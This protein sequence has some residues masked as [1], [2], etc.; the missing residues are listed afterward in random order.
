MKNFLTIV[1]GLFV[2]LCGIAALSFL[3]EFNYQIRKTDPVWELV[4]SDEFTIDG[5]PDSKLWK[6]DIGDGCPRL[7]GWGNNELQYYTD[8]IDNVY[9]KNGF[10]HIKAIKD[11]MG[12]RNYTSTRIKSKNDIQFGK[13][14]VK[15]KNPSVRGTW[16]AVW[17]L[18]SNSEYG[19]WPKSGEIDIMEHVGYNPDSIFGTVH[20]EA[21]NHLKNT[22][23][24]GA[25]AILNNERDF[26]TY[27]IIWT[28]EK[29][30]FT[31]DGEVYFSFEN[32]N[33]SS[34]EWP[35]DQNFHLIMNVAV[36]GNW[37][38]REGI[39]DNISGQEMIIDYVHV[40]EDTSPK[41][42]F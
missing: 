22:Q 12:L 33:L 36:G 42:L 19:T 5:K 24:G 41:K 1:F 14:E 35:F 38:G 20:T 15:L 40:Y 28:P 27:G 26:H 3:S 21:F 9:V 23:K 25:K 16:P 29:I 13:I 10:L 6:Y 30:D 4:W 17:M 37:G 11:S 31:I 34:A 32:E 2:I 39:S 8:S 7:C 18:P